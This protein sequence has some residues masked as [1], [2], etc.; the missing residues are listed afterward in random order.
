M[1]GGCF[2]TWTEEVP[3]CVAEKA[4]STRSLVA[5][6]SVNSCLSL[7]ILLKVNK[8]EVQPG[9]CVAKRTPPPCLQTIIGAENQPT[10]RIVSRL[11]IGASFICV[12]S[13]FFFIAALG[14][15]DR[16]SGKQ[17]MPSSSSEERRL[18]L[19]SAPRPLRTPSMWP[20]PP[21]TRRHPVHSMPL[22]PSRPEER[23]AD[24]LPVAESENLPK[25]ASRL[26]ALK[27]TLVGTGEAIDKLKE[28]RPSLARDQ[29]MDA[30][31]LCMDAM[32]VEAK[33]LEDGLHKVEKEGF[34][35][36][37]P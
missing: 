32:I 37:E 18:S 9:S 24:Q 3:R 5:G 15:D 8:G 11:M 16:R 21:T 31:R 14:A 6:L 28:E 23:S 17:P 26:E 19:Q 29:E 2:E 34:P 1:A 36:S 13:H 30:L 7:A 22:P 27:T 35:K 12:L 4:R 25:Y 33:V 10:M 20:P